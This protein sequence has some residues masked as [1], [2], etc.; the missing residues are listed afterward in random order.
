[1]I[2]VIKSG[3]ANGKAD[4]HQRKNRQGETVIPVARTVQFGGAH[5]SQSPRAQGA[6]DGG[7]VE[8]G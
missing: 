3:R 5:F 1:M 6:V 2:N 7:G 4:K 8:T